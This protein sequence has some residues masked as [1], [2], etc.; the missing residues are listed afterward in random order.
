MS[1]RFRGWVG[2]PLS[3]LEVLSAYL[4]LVDASY[5]PLLEVLVRATFIN[6]CE[7]PLSKY[8][9]NE[10]NKEDSSGAGCL[11]LTEKVK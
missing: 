7:F 3:P 6:S 10:E 9:S 5:P 1:L 2:I 4:W 11:N 8:L